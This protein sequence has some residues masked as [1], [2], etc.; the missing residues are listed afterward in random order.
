MSNTLTWKSPIIRDGFTQEAYIAERP[1]LHGELR[2]SYRPMLPE[3]VDDIEAHRST[4]K[5]SEDTKLVA[6]AVADRIVRLED[7]VGTEIEPTVESVRRLRYGI[8]YKV[9]NIIAGFEPSDL[10]PRWD[11]K[12]SELPPLSDSLMAKIKN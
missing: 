8:L 12:G 11:S 5:G 6:A 10:D 1:G 3:S 2:F 9:Y 4:K 7:G